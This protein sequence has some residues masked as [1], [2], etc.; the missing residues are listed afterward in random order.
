MKPKTCSICDRPAGS[1]LD[2][3]GIPDGIPLGPIQRCDICGRNA[4]PDCMHESECCFVEV[5]EH[6]HEPDWAPPGWR[7]MAVQPT[8]GGITYEVIG[9]MS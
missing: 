7:V 6:V 5:D 2:R 1:L 8:D 9:A 4:C 3:F